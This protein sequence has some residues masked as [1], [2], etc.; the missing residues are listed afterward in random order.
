MKRNKNLPLSEYPR[1]QLVR[2]SYIC[3]NGEWDYV[4]KN[5]PDIPSNFLSKIIVPFSPEAPLSKVNRIVQPDEYL[6][7]HRTFSL[8][9]GFN[10]G[11][12][13]LHFMAVDQIAKVYLNDQYLGE[14]IGGFLPFSFEIQ[15]YL[16]IENEVVVIV[17]DT[18]D[19]SYHSR[20]KQK[21]KRGGIW[22]TPQSGIYFPVWIESTPINYVSSLK[23]TPLFDDKKVEIIVDSNVDKEVSI[24]LEKRT[25]LAT[26]NTPI[27]IDLLNMHPWSVDD[28]YLYK[29]KVILGEDEVDSYFGMRKISI[30]TNQ[31]GKKI[32]FLNNK[33]L[34]Q[35]GL[36]DQGYY[37]DGLLT[38][39]SDNDYIDDIML[40]K[41]LGFNV[42]RKHIKIE[43]PRWYYHCDRLGM[44]V[45]QDFVNG[46]EDYSFFS[47]VVPAILQKHVKDN[48]YKK[49][50][51]QSIEGR[52]E[53][54]KE[55]K[56]TIELLY[57]YP[58][59]VLWTIFNEGWGQFD[60]KKVLEDMIKLDATRLFDHASGWHDQGG[61]NIKSDHVYFRRYKYED[62]KL[63]RARVLS[64]FG[65]YHL[66]IQG[67]AFN[68]KNFGYKRMKNVEHLT[69]AI[70][71]LFEGEI[72]PAARGGLAA[73]IYTQ[74]SDVED[75]LNGLITYDRKVIKVKA[76]PIRK[77]NYKLT[78]G[79]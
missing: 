35:S 49:F 58:S 21:L 63:S 60:A 4:I 25:I 34:F 72:L 55:A 77:I 15:D 48:K 24:Q 61:G 43:S 50:G 52:N 78:K 26:S 65:G 73:S 6:I 57:N 70:T 39:P 13:F 1:M 66:R 41:N 71:K 54:I 46:G 29:F 59:I 16:K 62:D 38:P 17:K 27:I 28:P 8:P 31:A 68:E 14:H 19:T 37:Q 42:L 7:Y 44:L 64:E 75:E 33:P 76:G 5:S 67:H 9:Q 69:S 53:F 18:S 20:G 2:D 22:Y 12:I 56:Q 47:T 11:R 45:W 79:R 30:E 3:L 51:R 32:F 36:L 23:I 74:L 10:K 40:A